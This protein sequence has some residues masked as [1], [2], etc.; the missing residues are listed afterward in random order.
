MRRSIAPT[1]L[2]VLF[3]A[4][5]VQL[6]LAIADRASDYEWFDPV[7][8]VRRILIDRFVRE[9]DPVAMQE[10]MIDGMIAVLDDPYTEYV[11]PVDE[12]EFNMVLRGTYTGIGAEVNTQDGYLL[13][14]TP[15]DDS[16]ALRAGVL[17]GDLVIE[18]EGE[19]TFETP[20][21]ELIDKLLGEPGTDV[22][23][24]VR[25]LDGTEE[26]LTVTRAHIE[27]HTV[28]G[29][30][31]NGEGWNH[32]VDEARGIQY[33]RITQFNRNTVPD[34]ATAL[35]GLQSSG[36]NGLILD[37]RDNPGGALPSAVG[38]AD[39]F[40]DDG[41]IVSVRPRQGD[42]KVFRA[43]AADTLPDFPMV[44][45]VN[46]NSASASEIVAGALQQNDRAKVLGTRS[47]GKGS[48][49]EVRELRYH[50][51]TLKYTAAYYHLPDGRNLHRLEDSTVWGVDPDPG[52]VVPVTDDDYR[53]LILA[54][55]EFQVIG[56][57]NVDFAA[58]VDTEWVRGT[59]H[60]EQLALAIE[61]LASR[62]DGTEW[63]A[64]SDADSGEVTV[65]LEVSRAARARTRVL[66]Q[67][68]AIESRIAELRG[69]TN[70]HAPFLPDD[71][72][73]ASGVIEV[74]DNLGNVIG[75]FRIDGGDVELALESLELTPTKGETPEP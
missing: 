49:Q 9:P 52:M 41:V 73:L 51:G 66:A 71:V 21:D 59:L 74:R 46:G 8:D 18:I 19:T 22:H 47:F 42:E 2:V 7:I 44:V 40:L 29:V 45:L 70:E 75:T 13:I 65:D 33:V 54:R 27:T 69:L 12:A 57:E 35:D 32:C 43:A 61:A 23:I 20:L 34:L 50:A 62:M 30:R 17:A 55:Q 31:R 4:L 36:L 10:A 67:L 37:L 28:K 48:V 60:D 3:G 11:P 24:R 58:C 63:A 72:D 68:E 25:H 56:A 38:M 16:P 1:L 26:D 6:P 5:L 64:V 39:L 14:V 15:M 53:T